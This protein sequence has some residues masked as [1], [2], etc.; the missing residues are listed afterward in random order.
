M[1]CAVPIYTDECVAHPA[2]T[3]TPALLAQDRTSGS[4]S[5]HQDQDALAFAFGELALAPPAQAGLV[6][7][8]AWQ[9]PLADVRVRWVL[10]RARALRRGRNRRR[11]CT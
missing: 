9:G 5:A 4:S 10:L 6:R 2:L 11:V 8:S 3:P 7:V 1:L